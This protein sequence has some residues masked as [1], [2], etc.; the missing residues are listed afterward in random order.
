MLRQLLYVPRRDYGAR[1]GT[2]RSLQKKM[3]FLL[4]TFSFKWIT[5]KQMCQQKFERQGDMLSHVINLV[6]QKSNL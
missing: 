4:R 3:G 6:E 2:E 5:Q 1:A